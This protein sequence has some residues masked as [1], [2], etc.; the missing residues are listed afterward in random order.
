M[1]FW[2]KRD[3]SGGHDKPKRRETGNTDPYPIEK[4]GSPQFLERVGKISPVLASA[5]DQEAWTR[6]IDFDHPPQFYL[7]QL[8]KVLYQILSNEQTASRE[9]DQAQ[10]V[11]LEES[12]TL[13]GMV[14]KAYLQLKPDVRK[15]TESIAQELKVEI[16]KQVENLQGKFDANPNSSRRERIIFYFNASDR[17]IV[18]STLRDKAQ[19]YLQDPGK[20][21]EVSP[22][23]KPGLNYATESNV[24][25]D[26]FV[27]QC[28][29]DKSK[30]DNSYRYVFAFF[31]AVE[32][33]EHF[34]A[35]HGGGDGREKNPAFAKLEQYISAVKTNTE[36]FP[37]DPASALNA[38]VLALRSGRN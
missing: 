1:P 12:G 36:Q 30:I 25:W 29:P 3:Q 20:L 16:L 6:E 26:A 24:A 23:V 33:A 22:S 10:F 28:I 9:Y 5:I 15:N 2:N 35:Q 14:I 27:K 31:C 38:I 21:R 17:E 18:L 37:K 11:Y 7:L 19:A 32:L 8:T 13:E 34:L 4:I